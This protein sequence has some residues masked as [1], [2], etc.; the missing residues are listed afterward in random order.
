VKTQIWTALIAMLLIKFLR[1]KSRMDWA[2]SNLVA[3]LWWNLFTHKNLW[4][5]IDDPFIRENPPPEGKLFQPLL[6]GIQ[7]K[8]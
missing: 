1:F 2:L 4:Q 8:V 7:A 5:W 3:L 6:D